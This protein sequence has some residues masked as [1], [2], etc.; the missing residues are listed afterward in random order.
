MVKFKA[1]ST[2]TCSQTNDFPPTMPSGLENLSNSE[3]FSLNVEAQ[4]VKK[5]VFH[6]RLNKDI[7]LPSEY[8][9]LLNVLRRA[10]PE[11]EVHIYINSPG[12]YLCSTVEI[13]NAM[14][15]CEGTIIT[16]ACGTIASAATMIFLAGHVQ[17]IM[18]D[19]E[20]MCHYYSTGFWGKGQELET[21][22]KHSQKSNQKFMWRF[23]KGFLTKKEF[24]ALCNGKDYWF[25]A[26]ELAKR[27]K[28]RIK[29]LGLDQPQEENIA[30]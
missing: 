3:H 8:T 12:G 30:Q 7:G 16:H 26:K 10:K 14:S 5:M 22:A 28:R 29:T 9:E 24:K 17:I 20:F 13:V 1:T 27:V 23:Y 6:L 25:G 18:E 4:I 21:Y 15:M 19:V 11:D 2:E